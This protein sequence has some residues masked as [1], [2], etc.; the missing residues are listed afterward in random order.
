MDN[1]K[2]LVLVITSLMFLV[3]AAICS[4]PFVQFAFAAPPDPCFGSSDPSCNTSCENNPINLQ[5]TCCWI[6]EATGKHTCQTCE[7]NTQT[8]EFENCYYGSKGRPGA[9]I[10]APPPSGVAPP[11]PTGTCPENTARDAQGNCTPLTQGPQET[12]P[13]PEEIAPTIDCDENPDDPLCET[14]TIPEAGDEGTDDGGEEG[15][16]DSTGGGDDAEGEDSSDGGNNPDE[17]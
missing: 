2:S 11:P 12:S 8:G 7:V 10:I 17:G 3:S 16:D 6:D 13:A 9:G 4:Q 15:A 5:A 14:A 1:T